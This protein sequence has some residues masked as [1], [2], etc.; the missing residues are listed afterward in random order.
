MIHSFIVLDIETTGLDPK[1]DKIIEIAAIKV[2]EG[3]IVDRF[4]T[5]INPGRFLEDRIQELTGIQ[6]EDLKKAPFIDEILGDFLAFAD[7]DCIM[8][9]SVLF[10]F[11]FLKRAALNQK[12]KFEKQG[13]DTLA[14]SRV[15]LR[16]LESRSLPVVANYYSIPHKPHRAMEDV[17]ATF[18]LYQCLCRDF[19]KPETDTSC[20]A[21]FTPK[22]LLYKVK[23]EGP[24]TA[25]QKENILKLLYDHKLESEYVIEKMTKNE[26]SRYYDQIIAKYG[27]SHPKTEES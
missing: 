8:G 26:A 23:K 17:L 2:V 11:S 5:L 13:I 20:E 25:H 15:Y 7:L 12:M 3:A 9:H 1:K 16:A 18:A 21:L 19:Y 22:K 14:L 24:I 27:R 6:N 4:E 10:D